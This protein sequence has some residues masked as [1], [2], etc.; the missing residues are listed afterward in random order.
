MLVRL[1]G[2]GDHWLAL[3]QV[4]G[5][6]PVHWEQKSTSGVTVTRGRCLGSDGLGGL[7]FFLSKERRRQACGWVSSFVDIE[8]GSRTPF[9]WS[10]I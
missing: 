7:V 1:P 5:S 6:A 4:R 9:S 8:S 3:T 2:G 10:S